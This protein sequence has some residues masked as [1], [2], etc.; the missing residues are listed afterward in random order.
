MTDNFIAIAPKGKEFL[1]RRTSMTAVPNGRAQEIADALNE[2]KYLI[3]DGE[4][5]HVYENSSY[6]NI[7]IERSLS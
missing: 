5:W 3:R 7:L 2:Q 1:Y 4:V 6:T